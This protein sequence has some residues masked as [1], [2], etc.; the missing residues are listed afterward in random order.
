MPPKSTLEY[1][2][3]RTEK[4]LDEIKSKL[5]ELWSF[6]WR[7]VGAAMASS[8]IMSIAIHG[9]FIYLEMRN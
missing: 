2:M 1:F 7:L 5:D 3:D 9:I 8:F 4:D 6:K